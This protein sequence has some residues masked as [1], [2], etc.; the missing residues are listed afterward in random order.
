VITSQRK[1]DISTRDECPQPGDAVI[2]RSGVRTEINY[3]VAHYPG[4]VVNARPGYSLGV[5]E[6]VCPGE[7]KASIT[8]S[9]YFGGTVA[10]G[11]GGPARAVW[12]EVPSR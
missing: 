7:R 9:V 1:I 4:F 5:W 2:K 10:G 12:Y 6:V 3:P 8:L 11:G